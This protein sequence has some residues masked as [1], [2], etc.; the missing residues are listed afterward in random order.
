MEDP[1]RKNK[2]I[3]PKYSQS[4]R[5]GLRK[6]AWDIFSKWVRFIRDKGR[7]YTCGAVNDPREC[8]AGHYKHSDALD[9]NEMNVHCQCIRCNRYLYGNSKS[10]RER[11]VRDYGED[12]VLELEFKAKQCYKYLIEEFEAVIKK[13]KPILVAEGIV[14]GK[15]LSIEKSH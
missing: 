8:D 11:L 12:K 10:Y 7:C 9:F 2:E 3:M 14:K 5:K 4:P 6:R 1:H 13:Y 15:K